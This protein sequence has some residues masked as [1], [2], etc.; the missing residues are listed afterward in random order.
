MGLGQPLQLA[1]QRCRPATRHPACLVARS[2]K[3]PLIKSLAVALDLIKGSL[4]FST[5]CNR[6]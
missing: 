5:V 1:L 4:G 6:M 2:P 3:E